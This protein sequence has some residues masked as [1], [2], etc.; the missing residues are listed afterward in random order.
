MAAIL[1]CGAEPL[2]FKSPAEAFARV[3][4]E[5]PLVLAVGEYHEVEGAA[6]TKSALKR[7]T[8]L[9]LP[10]LKGHASSLVV[11][12]WITNGRCGE[13]EVKAVAEVKK[14]TQRPQHTEDEVETL[15]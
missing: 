3:L 2:A 13:A 9:M 7:F 1:I 4:R 11:E 12:T 15:M 6:K 14:V 10:S 5:K 8:E